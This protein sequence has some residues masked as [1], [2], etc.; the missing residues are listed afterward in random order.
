[1]VE[2]AHLAHAPTI[3]AAIYLTVGLSVLVHGLSP[4]PLVSRYANWY[5]AAADKRPPRWRANRRTSTEPAGPPRCRASDRGPPSA[6]PV[7]T[8]VAATRAVR[9]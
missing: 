7:L 2:D 5:K 8:E 4:A 6:S 1:M 3:V 9:S